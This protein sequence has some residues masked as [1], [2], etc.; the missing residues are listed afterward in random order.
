MSGWLKISEATSLAL[1]TMA[2]LAG[3][4]GRRF[5]NREVAEIIGSSPAHLSKVMQRLVKAGL[6]NSMR[7][8]AGGFSLA[9][10]P[11]AITLR[12]IYEAIEGPLVPQGCLLH[13]PICGGENCVLGGLVE[14][15]DSQVRDYLTN[16]RLSQFKGFA[17]V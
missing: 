14:K 1:H 5:S 17:G 2:L 13:T 4:G 8:P 7:G 10:E 12:E 11:E 6:L 15:I 9:R 16:T 3:R